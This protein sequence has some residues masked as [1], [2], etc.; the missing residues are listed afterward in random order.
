MDSRTPEHWLG[1]Q[2][3]DSHHPIRAQVNGSAFLT[4]PI[5]VIGRAS[6]TADAS[7]GHVNVLKDLHGTFPFL[8]DQLVAVLDDLIV[9]A[10]GHEPGTPRKA[11]MLIVR[12][13]DPTAVA[14][15]E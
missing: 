8:R 11:M 12:R 2:V 5:P 4:S 7:T 15:D 9:I 3:S 14:D 10:K 13:A 6:L 1:A